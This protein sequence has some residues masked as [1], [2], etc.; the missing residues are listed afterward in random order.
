MDQDP[1]EEI[2]AAAAGDEHALESVFARN[3]APLVAFIRT[4]IGPHLAARESATD[5]AQSVFREVIQDLDAFEYRGDAAFRGWLYQQ[6]VRKIVNR[7]RFHFSQRRDIDREARPGKEDDVGAVFDCYATFGTPS[8]LV[9][10]REDL[11]R[12]ERAVES[13]PEKQ[14]DAVTMSRLLDLDYAEIAG[15][16]G[17]SE[18]AVRGLVAR[19]LATL[20]SQLAEP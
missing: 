3:M 14:R 2:R 19:G 11:E 7:N 10:A 6:A 1:A 8:R 5:L 9:A 12:F 17:C 4:R 20:A 15:L 13:L 18:S 16:M